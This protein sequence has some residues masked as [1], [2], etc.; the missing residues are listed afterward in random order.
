VRGNRGGWSWFGFEAAVMT[1]LCKDRRDAVVCTYIA[2][3]NDPLV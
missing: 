3:I 2:Y 1:L